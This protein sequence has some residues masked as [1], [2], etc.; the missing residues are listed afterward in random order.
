MSKPQSNH[1]RLLRLRQQLEKYVENGLGGHVYGA[2][3]TLATGETDFSFDYQE[4]VYSV[5]INELN[6]ED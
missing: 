2:G 5:H 4:H 6:K 3:T 1:V